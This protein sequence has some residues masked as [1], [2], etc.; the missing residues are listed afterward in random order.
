MKKLAIGCGIA[1]LVVGVACVGIVYYGYTKLRST[2][3]QIAE[4]GQVHDI[5]RGVKV[6]TP[7]VCQPR[8]RSFFDRKGRS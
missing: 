8:K 7:F 1:V 4:L 3:S 6:Q 2:V 5:E